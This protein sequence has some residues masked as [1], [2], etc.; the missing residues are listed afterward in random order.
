MKGVSRRGAD[1]EHVLDIASFLRQVEAFEQLDPVGARHLAE[2][3]REQSFAAG[4]HIIR[5]HQAGDCMYVLVIGEVEVPIVDERGERLFTVRLGPRQI[6]GEMA[7]LT[8]EPRTADVIAN[9]DCHCLVLEKHSVEQLMREQPPIARFLTTILGHR[10]LAANGIKKVGKYRLVGELGRGSMGI[11]YEAIHPTLE[12]PVAIKMLSHELVYRPQ[13]VE[14]FRNEAKII[15]RL[16]QPG[17]VE[18]F[19]TEEAYATFFI[20]MEKLPGNSLEEEIEA[21]GRLE[22]EAVRGILRQLA[23]ALDLAHRHG[24]VHRDVKPSNIVMGRSG[25]VKL[26]DFGLA[27]DP[28]VETSVSGGETLR[29]GTPVYMSP[30]QI[31][32]EELS[33]QSD[34]YSL[35]IIAYEMLVGEPPY[36]GNIP[37]IMQQHLHGPVPD[38]GL[39]RPDLS[40]DLRQFVTRACAKRPADRFADCAEVLLHLGGTKMRSVDLSHLQAETL[41]CVYPPERRQEV[42]E[43][44]KDARLR[45]EKLPGVLVR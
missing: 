32:G 44:F 45:L 21:C 10:L 25:Q 27:L 12:R 9:S 38:P 16:R 4:D 7:L 36:A 6:F 22:E 18:V 40:D 29:V 37:Q 14:R 3:I 17:I 33:G 20:V 41:T 31:E 15:A 13:F 19:D 35:G 2:E 8:G 23:A 24:I 34:I 28:E 11:V 43:I 1:W 42:E 5:R 26:M 39:R 30:E